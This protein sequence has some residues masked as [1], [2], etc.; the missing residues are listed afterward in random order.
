MWTKAN[1]N[2][3]ESDNRSS[4]SSYFGGLSQFLKRKDKDLSPVPSTCSDAAVDV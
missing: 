3:S 4:I 2:A 1:A